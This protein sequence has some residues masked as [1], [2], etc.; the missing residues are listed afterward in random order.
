MGCIFLV[1]VP[2]CGVD[3]V[4]ALFHSLIHKFL[5]F[6]WFQKI[7]FKTCSRDVVA[8][9]ELIL[10]SSGELFRSCL[11]GHCCL[12]CCLSDLK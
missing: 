6:I 9:V 12:F 7:N 2:H 4:V 10:R 11:Y 1:S 8:I 3:V 5:A